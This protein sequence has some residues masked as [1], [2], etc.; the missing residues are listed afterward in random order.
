APEDRRRGAPRAARARPR[1]LRAGGLAL[2]QGKAPGRRRDCG[3]GGLHRHPELRGALSMA[4]SLLLRAALAGIALGTAALPA[5]AD[6]LWLQPARGG[7]AEVR[8]GTLAKPL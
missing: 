7:Q 4:V 3:R 5:T 8:A 6:S 1:P 2:G